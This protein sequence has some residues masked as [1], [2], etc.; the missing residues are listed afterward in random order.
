[1][2]VGMTNVEDTEDGWV[3]ADQEPYTKTWN[4][5]TLGHVY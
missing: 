3:D 1:M 4:I 5:Y 2:E